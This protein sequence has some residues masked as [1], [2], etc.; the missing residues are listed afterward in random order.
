VTS[1]S[2]ATGAGTRSRVLPDARLVEVMVCTTALAG[3]RLNG[4]LAVPVALL[5]GVVGAHGLVL[6]AGRPG[7]GCGWPASP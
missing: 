3:G 7:G 6:S 1:T 5:A 2:A 4:R